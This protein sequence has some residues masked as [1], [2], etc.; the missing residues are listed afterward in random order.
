[1]ITARHKLLL[2]IFDRNLR[3]F[4][5]ILL[6]LPFSDNVGIVDAVTGQ[7]AEPGGVQL[8]L[9]LHWNEKGIAFCIQYRCG[10]ACTQPRN[11]TNV[12]H[13]LATSIY[14]T[15]FRQQG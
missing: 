2:P 10:C 1:M 8:Q 4:A 14:L 13:V 7:V 15:S 11:E 6:G 12:L 9:K 3:C 5:S